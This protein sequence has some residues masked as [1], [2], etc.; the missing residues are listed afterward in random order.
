MIFK[1]HELNL[2]VEGMHCQKCVARITDALK[3]IPD[4]KKVNIDLE[5]KAVAVISKAQLDLSIV[6]EAIEA[7]GFKVVE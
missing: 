6:K 2:T 3:K 4:V 1:K 7:L 5:K